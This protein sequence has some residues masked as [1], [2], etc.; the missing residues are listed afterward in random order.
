MRELRSGLRFVSTAGNLP[1]TTRGKRGR[2]VP[3]FLVTSF[4]ASR[5]KTLGRQAETPFALDPQA[6]SPKPE[7]HALSPLPQEPAI[8]RAHVYQTAPQ[9]TV[10]AV[11][12]AEER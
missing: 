9:C 12:G 3:S 11:T 2:G 8:S 6:T 10:V 5:K 7:A 1:R 4:W